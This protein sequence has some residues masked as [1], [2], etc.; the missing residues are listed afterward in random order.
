MRTGVV[1]LSAVL[2]AMPERLWV[3]SIVVLLKCLLSESQPHEPAA[4][5]SVKVEFRSTQILAKSE[6][7]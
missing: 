4:R 1:W 3:F 5:K 2:V 7:I 6:F